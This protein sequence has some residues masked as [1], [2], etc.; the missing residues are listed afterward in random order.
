MRRCGPSTK[1]AERRSLLESDARETVIA[2]LMHQSR[3]A[4]L[5]VGSGEWLLAVIGAVAAEAP[6]SPAKRMPLRARR[7]F[8]EERL[9]A[10]GL[11]Y[12]TGA[13]DPAVVL[14]TEAG[15]GTRAYA[16]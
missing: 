11:A 5:P 15:P 13:Q 4:E 8:L 10:S 14:D 1:W 12:G 6:A 16:H 9:H 2:R 3:M 7:E